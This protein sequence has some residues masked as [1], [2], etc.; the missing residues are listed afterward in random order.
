MAAAFPRPN[1]LLYGFIVLSLVIHVFV[2]LHIAG[3]YESR[4]ISYIELSMLQLSAPDA[5]KIPLPRIRL[6]P[7]AVSQVKTIQAPKIQIPP[8]RMEKILDQ[9]IDRAHVKI[10]LPH[11]PAPMTVSGFLVP[12]LHLPGSVGNQD[13]SMEFASAQEYFEMLQMRIHRFKQYPDAAKT[14]HIQGRVKIQFILTDDGSLTQI[15][16][17]KSSHHGNLD[18]AAMDAIKRASPFPRPPGF[19]IKTPV[20]LQIDIL[21]ELL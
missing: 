2:F 11:L 7:S 6:K 14:N 4:A 10:D 13:T 21:F 20:T 18:E 9:K 8:I 17:L 5:R 15:K 19:L 12:G 3:I 16:L 1:F